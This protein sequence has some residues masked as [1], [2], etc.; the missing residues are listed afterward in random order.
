MYIV[1]FFLVWSVRATILF[2]IDRSI[3]STLGLYLYA[4]GIK[5]LLWTV[6]VFVYLM[7]VDRV[8]P[9]VYLKLITPISR[10]GWLFIGGGVIAIIL[11]VLGGVWLKGGHGLSE[12]GLQSWFMSL[13]SVWLSPISEEILF[14]GFILQKLQELI[15]FWRANLITALLFTLAHW[16]NWI[17]VQGWSPAIITSSVGIF[18][19]GWIFGYVMYKTNSLWPSIGLHILNNFLQALIA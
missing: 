14:R 19:L 17:W 6:P 15:D 5:I 11:L 10:S 16:P 7:V 18:A 13:V 12:A 1:T 8:N 2:S 3:T 4:N 9:L